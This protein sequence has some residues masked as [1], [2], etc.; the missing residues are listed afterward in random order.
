MAAPVLLFNAEQ[1]SDVSVIGNGKGSNA[2]IFLRIRH[3]S[4]S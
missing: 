2:I 4:S 1:L 3:A